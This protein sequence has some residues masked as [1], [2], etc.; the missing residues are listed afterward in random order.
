MHQ[1]KK[2]TIK[3][4]NCFCSCKIC[5][6]AYCSSD[7]KLRIS[8]SCGHIV[9]VTLGSCFLRTIILH[10][11]P[12]VLADQSLSHQAL[13]IRLKMRKPEDSDLFSPYTWKRLKKPILLRQRKLA[14]GTLS[15]IT[16]GRPMTAAQKSE[17]EKT[18]RYQHELT[19]L[20]AEGAAANSSVSGKHK[21]FVGLLFY[22]LML[23][24]RWRRG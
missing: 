21:P 11:C 18:R 8:P 20:F 3:I 13:Y 14:A 16:I 6:T 10:Y 17:L 12:I 19:N 2:R 22:P 1:M 9:T 23:T 5:T 7:N 4:S 15:P 24:N